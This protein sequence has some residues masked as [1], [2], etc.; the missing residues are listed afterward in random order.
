MEYLAVNDHSMRVNNAAAASLL[1]RGASYSHSQ[2][3]ELIQRIT[4][5]GCC[6]RIY[7]KRCNLQPKYESRC[8]NHTFEV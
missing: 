5:T 8:V 1:G 3:T 7:D 4:Y 6:D 2:S